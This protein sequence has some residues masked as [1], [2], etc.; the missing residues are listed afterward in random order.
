MIHAR[1]KNRF[2][3]DQSG[4][5]AIEFAMLAPF[6]VL[7]F[8]G[9]VEATEYHNTG[10]RV[11]RAA[12]MLADLASLENQISPEELDDMLVGVEKII[13]PLDIQ[14][15][16][17]RIISVIPDDNGDPIV[18][19]SRANSDITPIPY[20]PDAAYIGLENPEVLQDGFSLLV[21]EVTYEHKSDLT[22]WVLGETL[23][24]SKSRI[25]TPR[26]SQEVELCDL[27]NDGEYENCV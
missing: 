19:W 4:I 21:A 9:A 22:G 5:A 25:R 15:L 23:H 2:L 24:Y 14:R 20:V 26:R 1:F 18:H 13:Q 12:N 8:F 6:M 11:T 27:G 7:L 3:K 16:T 17:M 10:D